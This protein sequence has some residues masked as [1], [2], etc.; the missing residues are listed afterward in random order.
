M[1]P[2][3]G[4]LQHRTPLHTMTDPSSRDPKPL[5]I[6]MRNQLLLLSR[7]TYSSP[8]SLSQTKN[9]HNK[10]VC[11]SVIGLQEWV[12]GIIPFYFS[13]V[14][15]NAGVIFPFSPH[16]SNV[17]Q[18][19]LRKIQSLSTVLEPRSSSNISTTRDN[20]LETCTPWPSSNTP[21]PYVT[22]MC[23][24]IGVESKPG[25]KHSQKA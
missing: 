5:Q 13:S 2:R 12:I 19:K 4:Y 14:F 7:K 11:L 8:V 15:S 20:D 1:W 10:Q 23:W 16:I 21:F 18:Q 22:D 24:I 3:R 25:F 6:W 17:P 9:I